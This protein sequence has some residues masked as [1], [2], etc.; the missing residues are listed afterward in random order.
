MLI[1]GE[2]INASRKSIQPLIKEKDA[3]GIAAIAKAQVECG[4]DY[5]DVNAGVFVEKEP[6]YLRWLVETV[7]QAVDAP[8]CIDS[9]NPKALEAA[10]EVHKGTPLINSISLEAD[11]YDAVL[12]VVAG[13]DLKVIALCVSEGE[14]PHTKDER[15]EIA[16]KLVNGLAQNGVKKDN[17]FV[18][19][20]AQPIATND[21]S[22]VAFLDALQGVHEAFHEVHT[23][24][25]LSNVSYGVPNRKFTNR[26]FMAMAI[27]KGLDGA[28]VDPRDKR[29]MATII[30]AETLIGRDRFC[31]KY[32]NAHRAKLFDFKTP[33]ATAK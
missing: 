1:V 2:L 3:Q 21:A 6:E 18:D 24:C 23:I 27:T 22:G 13:T 8:C 14:M 11:R 7:Q 10:L 30:A 9:P 12:S 31:E 26:T 4:A 5:I 20:L 25:G 32:L 19:P 15:M 16:D 28:I 33:G 17:I 29:M